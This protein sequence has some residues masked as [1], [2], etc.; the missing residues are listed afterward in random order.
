MQ[1]KLCYFNE[2]WNIYLYSEH[3]HTGWLNSTF[4]VQTVPTEN[5]GEYRLRTYTHPE[6]P[7]LCSFGFMYNEANKDDR[8]GHGGEWSSNSMAI[9]K[10]F[11]TDLY[12]VGL[13]GIGVAISVK[14]F[15]HLLGDKLQWQDDD[16]YGCIITDVKGVENKY[17][18]W[19]TQFSNK[20]QNNEKVYSV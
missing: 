18:A 2:H 20:I 4:T 15:K 16:I 10:I 7:L 19:T 8:P 11:G 1:V 13:D 17:M 12:E 14:W 6:I 9:N 3:E 5:E